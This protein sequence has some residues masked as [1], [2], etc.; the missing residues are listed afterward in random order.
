MARYSASIHGTGRYV[1]LD[2]PLFACGTVESVTVPTTYTPPSP[3][4]RFRKSIG[5]GLP[6]ISLL[7]PPLGITTFC[8]ITHQHIPPAPTPCNTYLYMHQLISLT[9]RYAATSTR[10]ST[11]A[12][13]SKPPL[14]LDHFLLHQRAISLYRTIIRGCRQAPPPTREEMRRYAREEFERHKAVQD[15]RKIRYLLSTGKSEFERV[16]KQVSGMGSIF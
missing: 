1:Y 9:R 6:R 3:A 14:S 15:A 16:G 2:N 7:I 11:L 5:L 8:P 13:S 4:Y 10:S 12:S